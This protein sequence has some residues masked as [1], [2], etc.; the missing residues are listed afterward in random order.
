MLG[1][2]KDVIIPLQADTTIVD[3]WLYKDQCYLT[4]DIALNTI[5][6]II[7]ITETPNFT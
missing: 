1:K 5:S 2:V 4:K 3:L 7:I 6:C